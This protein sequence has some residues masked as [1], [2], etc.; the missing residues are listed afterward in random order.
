M[1]NSKWDLKPSIGRLYIGDSDLEKR[2]RDIFEQ[3]K[4]QALPYITFTPRNEW[5]WLALAQHHGLPTRLLDWTENPLVAL[6]FA[7]QD[8]SVSF[9]AVVYLYID[10]SAPINIRSVD[11]DGSQPYQDPLS[12]PSNPEAPRYIPAHLN[13]RIIAQSGL[14]TIHPTPTKPFA[15]E[16]IYKIVIPKNIRRR[17]KEQLYRYGVHEGTVYPSLDGLS[18]KI[19]WLNSDI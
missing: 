9:D 8:E 19:K 5:E 10:N 11:T 7:V 15:S 17:L 13:Q 14:F 4:Q 18:R 2:E 6:Y 16:Q 3:F 12:I 1:S